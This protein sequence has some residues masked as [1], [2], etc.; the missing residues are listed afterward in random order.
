MKTVR[1][2]A[3][4]A[5]V[6]ALVCLLASCG[7]ETTDIQGAGEE[8][9]AESI[10]GD[11]SEGY[12]LPDC[13]DTN[14]E[15]C[16]TNGFD[17][18]VDGF[19]F[20]NWGEP[21]TIGATEMIALFGRENVCASGS[22]SSCVMYPAA[23]Q[24]ASQVN[25]SM[26]GGHC[27][28]MA[29]LSARLFL[30][31]D[32][33]DRLDPNAGSTY[34]LDPT[35]RDVISSIDMWFAT[36]YLD[37]VVRAYT[38]Y[39]ELTPTEIASALLDG[40]AEG[41]GY[42]LGIYSEDGGHAVTPLGVNF[43]GDQVAISI[44]D[45][46]Y[47]GTVQ[48]VMVDPDQETWSYAGGTTEPNAPTD[49]W[50]GTTGTIELTPME[51]RA[52]PAPAP[53]SEE[54]EKG[55]MRNQTVLVTSPDPQT[56]AGAVLDVDGQS[57]DLTDPNVTPPMGVTV[58]TI[59][60]NTLTS[61]STVVDIDTELVTDYAI[62]A[63]TENPSGATVPVTIS[64]DS[65]SKPRIR[66]QTNSPSSKAGVA[67]FSVDS[68]GT[69]VADNRGSGRASVS[70]ANGLRGATF[71]VDEEDS[72]AI[73]SDD[74]GVAT[75]FILDEDGE[76]LGTFEFDDETLDGSVVLTDLE[77]DP[78]TGEFEVT[79]VEADVDE[80]DTEFLALVDD[81]VGDETDEATD[82]GSDETTDPGSDDG[83]DLGVDEG[84]DESTDQGTNE[85]TEEGAEESVDQGTDEGRIDDA[86]AEEES[87]DTGGSDGGDQ[88]TEDE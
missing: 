65:K 84:T 71:D 86:P 40:Q 5:P 55:R 50:E 31:V 22:G 46:N 4:I 12:P 80:V 41:A 11:F 7:S 85:S 17:P 51:S 62:T 77:F 82:E 43:V 87:G 6:V 72:L 29:V 59:R 63:T 35:D 34:E 79:E 13:S 1:F 56:M 75:I 52:L 73:D 8:A 23:E 3:R 15:P 27:E 45:N 28:G 33:L 48:R 24:W 36:Q 44:Y 2:V 30:G 9:A 53:F 25:E 67:R 37:P 57:Y 74:E 68:S 83:S 58:R 20:A 81:I 39:Q 78:E 76:I 38:A 19:G 10:E 47:P 54:I 32:T 64:L 49:G 26:A 70:I 14:G 16:I 66:M 88:V 69:V 60:G 42:T 61:G 21:G 18:D